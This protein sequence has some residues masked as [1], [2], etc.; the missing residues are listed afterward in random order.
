MIALIAGDPEAARQ[1]LRQGFE[2]LQEMGQLGFA[3]GAAVYLARALLDLGDVATARELIDFVDA[4]APAD[5]RIARAHLA[6]LAARIAP[7][8]NDEQIDIARAASET[9]AAT[10]ELITRADSLVD[11]ASVLSRCDRHEEGRGALQESLALYERRASRHRSAGWQRYSAI[12][13]VDS[14]S[15]QGCSSGGGLCARLPLLAH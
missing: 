4:T 2:S 1:E 15:W 12:E 13:Q 14:G 7:N 5:D 8:P 10:D 9:M 11:L 6:L 3:V